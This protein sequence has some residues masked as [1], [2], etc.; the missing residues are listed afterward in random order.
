LRLQ[1]KE[2]IRSANICLGQIEI[3]RFVLGFLCAKANSQLSF[4]FFQCFKFSCHKDSHLHNTKQ[5]KMYLF[6]LFVPKRLE[7]SRL[8]FALA[9]KKGCPRLVNSPVIDRI[10]L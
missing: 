7:M 4:P 9:T 6:F 2:Y 8:Y 5:A 10:T 1:K 3:S